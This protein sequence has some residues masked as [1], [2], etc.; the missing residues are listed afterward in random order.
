MKDERIKKGEIKRKSKK[1][2]IFFPCKL[3]FERF[4]VLFRFKE[5]L[6]QYKSLLFLK[7]LNI[8][9]KKIK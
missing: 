6:K 2:I 9:T 5:G 3:L 7:A 1:L 4:S 8:F